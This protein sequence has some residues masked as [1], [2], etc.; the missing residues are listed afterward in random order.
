MRMVYLAGPYSH[1]DEEIQRLRRII[2]SHMAGLILIKEKNVAIIDPITMS[3]AIV[4]RHPE[5]FNGGF[6][7]WDKID[8]EFIDRCDEV[9]V[10]AIEGYQQSVGVQAE[11]AYAKKKGKPVKFID[12]TDEELDDYH[13]LV[14]LTA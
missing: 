12:F 3:A 1:Q 14:G 2:F 7:C 11:I 8:Y 5:H 10:M 4:D 13:V 6:D 9:Y